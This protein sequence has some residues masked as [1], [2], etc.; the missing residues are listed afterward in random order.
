[1]TTTILL[2]RHGQTDWN[3]DGRWQGHNDIPLNQT[4]LEQAQALARR[5]AGWP[6]T[7]LYSSDLQRASQT[8]VIL[9]NALRLEPVLDPIWRER[10]VGAFGGLTSPEVAAT[11]PDIW[12]KRLTGILDPP[13]GE[14][15]EA[16]HHRA[17]QALN[18]LLGHH[19]GDMVAV[20]SH[21]GLLHAVAAHVLGTNADQYSRL[22]FRGNTGLSI[23]EVHDGHAT[24][25]R[26]ND[27]SHLE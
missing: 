5:L 9:G 26:L 18:Q 20:V 3:R 22:S 21:G 24:L 8:A 4:G 23:I 7:H 6:V 11:F 15:Y 17:G 14:T 16:M 1:M 2:I 10:D 19:N 12:A 25:V 13:E 27:T